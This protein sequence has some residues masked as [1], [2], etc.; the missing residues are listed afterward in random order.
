MDTNNANCFGTYDRF[1]R[2][3]PYRLKEIVKSIDSLTQP[4]LSG[5]FI[6]QKEKKC[7]Q[8]TIVTVQYTM[9]RRYQSAHVTAEHKLN[10]SEDLYHGFISGVV[11]I[12]YA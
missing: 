6:A 8:F 10:P 9:I 4:L 2:S 12:S 7:N 3:I 1:D 11:K 5:F